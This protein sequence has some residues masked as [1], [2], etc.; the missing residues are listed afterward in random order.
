MLIRELNGTL[1]E[2]VGIEEEVSGF[3][4]YAIVN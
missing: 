4:G 2:V 1:H 3:D